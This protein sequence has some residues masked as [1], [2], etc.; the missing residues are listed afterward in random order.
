MVFKPIVTNAQ[1]ADGQE[2]GFVS[3]VWDKRVMS[4]LFDGSGV[5]GTM[6]AT[7]AAIGKEIVRMQQPVTNTDRKKDACR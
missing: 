3:A 1:Y 6:L 4:L 5:S 7:I 2:R